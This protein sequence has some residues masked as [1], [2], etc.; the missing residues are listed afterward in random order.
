MSAPS[1]GDA[2]SRL[3]AVVAAENDSAL[4]FAADALVALV[5]AVQRADNAPDPESQVQADDEVAD[6][7]AMLRDSLPP[8]EGSET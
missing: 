8:V 1:P 7:L 6:A 4:W 5:E 3:R 2:A